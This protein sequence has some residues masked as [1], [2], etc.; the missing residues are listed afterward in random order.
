MDIHRQNVAAFE[1]LADNTPS[2]AH[3]FEKCQEI[4]RYLIVYT[5]K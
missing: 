1:A 2:D 3:L 4:F 5:C